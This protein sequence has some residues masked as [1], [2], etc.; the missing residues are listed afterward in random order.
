MGQGIQRV[1][2][3]TEIREVIDRILRHLVRTVK[4]ET[5]FPAQTPA[6]P[7]IPLG[8]DRTLVPKTQFLLDFDRFFFY[9]FFPKKHLSNS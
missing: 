2:G 9:T 8:W 3:I 6:L 1:I 4:A 5:R 7:G